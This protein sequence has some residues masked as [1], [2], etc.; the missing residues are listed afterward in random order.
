MWE[1]EEEGEI[2]GIGWNFFFKKKGRYM[3]HIGRHRIPIPYNNY[4]LGFD[5]DLI[6]VGI[7]WAF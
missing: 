4:T 7:V 1:K 6:F 3:I 2:E 5:Y